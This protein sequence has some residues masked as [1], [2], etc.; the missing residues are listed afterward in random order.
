METERCNVSDPE[1][2]NPEE[3]E[4]SDSGIWRQHLITASIPLGR[5]MAQAFCCC[6]PWRA[7]DLRGRKM[8][9]RKLKLL[10]AWN[11]PVLGGKREI[12]VTTSY[13]RTSGIT[14]PFSLQEV[15]RLILVR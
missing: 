14:A 9:S 5:E 12:G 11:L 6:V 7:L 10:L 3:Y 2:E 8:I 13:S 1:R 4:V 15:I